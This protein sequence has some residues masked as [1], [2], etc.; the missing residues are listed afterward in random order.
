MD[1][2]IEVFKDFPGFEDYYEISNW[3]AVRSKDRWV[4]NHF[5]KGQIL[6]PEI[7]KNKYVRVRVRRKHFLLHRAMALAFLPNPLG[8]PQINH[9]TQ[10]PLDN[11]IY[12]N[13]DGS[14]DYEKTTIEWCDVRYNNLYADGNEKRTKAKYKPVRRISD[15]AEFP[16][17][18]EAAKVSKVSY[19]GLSNHLHGKSKTCGGEKWEYI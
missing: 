12:I 19:E 8:L 14:I 7:T 3:G 2:G 18:Q 6:K 15:G 10:N 1:R 9:K 16:S 5:Y 17:L 11:F 4:N 13:P